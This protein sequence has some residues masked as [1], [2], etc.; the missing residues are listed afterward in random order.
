MSLP[1]LAAS[2]S[3]F[4]PLGNPTLS[5]HVTVDRR[6]L[7]TVYSTA[8]SGGGCHDITHHLNIVSLLQDLV[9]Q[10]GNAV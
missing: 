1:T 7:L 8:A 6:I 4:D 2:V 3:L 9:K 5:F 10:K